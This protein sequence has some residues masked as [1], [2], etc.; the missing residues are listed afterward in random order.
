MR[1]TWQIILLFLVGYNLMACTSFFSSKE[2]EVVRTPIPLQSGLWLPDIPIPT[3]IIN[4][5]TKLNIRDSATVIINNPALIM[6]L[7]YILNADKQ[8]II[9]VG[10]H[11]YVFK[12]LTRPTTNGGWEVL[13]LGT[14][15]FIKEQPLQL[16]TVRSTDTVTYT[17]AELKTKF[18][19]PVTTLDDLD[20]L[21]Q[22]T[23]NWQEEGTDRVVVF[24]KPNCPQNLGDWGGFYKMALIAEVLPE[25]GYGDPVMSDYDQQLLFN[26]TGELVYFFLKNKATSEWERYVVVSMT[27]EQWTL[28]SLRPPYSISHW[29][30]IEEPSMP[31]K[32]LIAFHDKHLAEMRKF[33]N[34][35]CD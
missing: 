10:N 12:R 29:N 20:T 9:S 28:R 4:T 34:W 31:L 26:Y 11:S 2:E 17:R 3:E 33:G 13:S 25:E 19:W 5:V 22:E 30:R 8:E 6:P 18:H 21:L 27:P 24:Y 15:F 35:N 23:S 32:K 7:V 16:Q 14:T 1:Q